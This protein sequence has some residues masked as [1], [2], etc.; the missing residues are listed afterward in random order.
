MMDQNRNESNCVNG[1]GVHD[2]G[3]AHGRSCVN[4]EHRPIVIQLSR[5]K[6]RLG[7]WNVGT[8]RGRSGKVV[9]VL[10]RRKIDVC[11][12]QEVR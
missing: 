9:E 8:M 11:C 6:F 7:S 4:L 3:P 1:S 2:K 10:T 12:A 5:T